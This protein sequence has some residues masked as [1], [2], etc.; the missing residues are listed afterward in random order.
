MAFPDRWCV[1][2][3]LERFISLPSLSRIVTTTAFPRSLDDSRGNDATSGQ[4]HGSGSTRAG[5][6]PLE[7]ED[8]KGEAHKNFQDRGPGGGAGTA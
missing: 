7:G 3:Y 1:S 5:Y 6:Q 8:D 2:E 4:F